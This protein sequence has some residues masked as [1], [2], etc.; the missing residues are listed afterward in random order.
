MGLD[1][2]TEYFQTYAK[3]FLKREVFVKERGVKRRP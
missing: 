3:E 1:L 2:E